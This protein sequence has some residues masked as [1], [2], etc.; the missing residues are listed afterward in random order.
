MSDLPFFV[1]F[2][3]HEPVN[4]CQTATF[5]PDNYDDK[6]SIDFLGERGDVF[7][8]WEFGSKA[9]RDDVFQIFLKTYSFELGEDYVG[10]KTDN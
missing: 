8:S 2:R 4:I 10:Q 3:N 6:F 7:C 1:H 9:L 5:S